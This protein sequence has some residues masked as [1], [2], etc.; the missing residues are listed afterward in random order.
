MMHRNSKAHHLH[1]D[2]EAG[3]H[4]GAWSPSIEQRRAGMGE[5]FL[6]HE[7]VG[8]DCGCNVLLVDSNRDSHEHLLRTFYD[9]AVDFEKVGPLQSLPGSA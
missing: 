8:F 6:R 7:M 5:E 1:V 2:Q 9:S 4:L 3:G